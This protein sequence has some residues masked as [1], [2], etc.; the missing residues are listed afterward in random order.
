MHKKHDSLRVNWFETLKR[1]D[2]TN[3]L[4]FWTRDF[5]KES[6]WSRFANHPDTDIY[7]EAI[8]N[9]EIGRSEYSIDKHTFRTVFNDSWDFELSSKCLHSQSTFRIWCWLISL[10]SVQPF[11]SA[12][13]LVLSGVC[14]TDKYHSWHL[15][16]ALRTQR[17][18][19]N[20]A[21]GAASAKANQGPRRS[22]AHEENIGKPELRVELHFDG[23]T[24]LSSDL[25]FDWS[26]FQF[27]FLGHVWSIFPIVI[28][29]HF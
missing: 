1:F 24:W 12:G 2:L 15:Q 13:G 3:Q 16:L 25:P 10:K 8:Q 6:C 5:R 29:S 4:P 14:V 26:H 27:A 28:W 7:S 9:C 19:V 22:A 20:A 11:R 17:C 21:S 23:S 18:G